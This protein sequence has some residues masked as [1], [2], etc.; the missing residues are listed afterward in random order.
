MEVAVAD[1]GKPAMVNG[2][3]T[4]ES[5]MSQSSP[6]SRAGSLLLVTRDDE[7]LGGTTQK[8]CTDC[9]TAE[10]VRECPQCMYLK[11][12]C[13]AETDSAR[14]WYR[15]AKGVAGR[16][17]FNSALCANVPVQQQT[18]EGQKGKNLIP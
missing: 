12:L 7:E 15:V 1:V 8:V 3:L 2:K 4:K 16:G 18:G 13:A 14:T 11:G 6:G 17:A 9:T 10:C 5:P